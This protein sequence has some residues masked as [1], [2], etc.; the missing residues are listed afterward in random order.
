MPE[1]AN[2]VTELRR[3][4]DAMEAMAARVASLEP[5]P[6]RARLVHEVASRFLTHARAEQR[7]LYPAL[8]RYLPAGGS[9]AVEQTRQDDA[10]EQIALSIDRAGEDSDAYEALVN[11]LML[12][13]QRHVATQETVL[14]PTLLDT[15]PPEDLNNLGRQLR[16]G[17]ADEREGD[18]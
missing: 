11:Q 12:D 9:D 2:A 15:C 8:R 18:A 5:C 4:H 14:L 1:G 16:A 7:F 3:E 10:A 17:L 6:E 13:I